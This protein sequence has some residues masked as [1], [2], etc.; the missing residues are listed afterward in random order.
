[1][2]SASPPHT[3]IHLTDLTK[4]YQQGKAEVNALDGIS[5]AIAAGQFV[6]VTGASGSGKSTL[7]HLIAG[8]ARPTSGDITVYGQCISAM[9]DEQLTS[10]R[11]RQIGLIFQSFNLL[12]TLNALEN[13]ALPLLIN[14]QPMRPAREDAARMLALVGLSD[15]AA[16]RPDELSGGQQQRVAIARALVNEAPLLLADEPTGNLDSKTGEDILN[17]LRSLVT[18]QART[19]IM[20]TH[21]PRAAAYADQTITLSDGQVIGHGHLHP[22][23]VRAGAV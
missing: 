20:V 16:H 8:L 5:L 10:F 11:R 14:G 22:P 23:A 1:M 6:A 13:A 17:L 3:A 7:L 12:P 2:V 21:D 9:N 19:V 4:V 18:D 15:R